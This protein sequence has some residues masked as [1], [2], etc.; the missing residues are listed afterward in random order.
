MAFCKLGQYFIPD[1]SCSFQEW[2]T[3]R[4]GGAIMELA[5]CR[6]LAAA[7]VLFVTGTAFAGETPT[8]TQRVQKAL[9]A[10]LAE[11]SPL[12]GVTGIAAY[13]SL[14]ASGPN[15]EAFAG[16]TGRA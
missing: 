16:K 15:I 1:L 2:L 7:I 8:Q 10:W 6:G 14:G 11:R 4:R 13:V 3:S 9:D 12:E 5:R